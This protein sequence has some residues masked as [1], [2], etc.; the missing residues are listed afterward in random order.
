MNSRPVTLIS[1]DISD[2][3]ALTPNH[4]LTGRSSNNTSPGYFQDSEV[5]LRSKWRAVQAA[6]DIF[7]KRWIK[8]YLPSL[9]ERKKWH[10]EVRN[11]KVGD[12]VIMVEKQIPRS[13]WQMARILKTFPGPDGITRVVEIT[14]VTGSK[15]VRPVASLCLLEETT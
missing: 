9:S 15:L 2:Y 5:N 4:F 10:K 3:N 12:L 13:A 7:W 6:T 11:M 1:D 8:E 14:T